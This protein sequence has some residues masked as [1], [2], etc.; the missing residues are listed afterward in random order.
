MTLIYQFIEQTDDRGIPQLC[1]ARNNN[2]TYVL[3]SA[4]GKDLYY[5]Y[6]RKYDNYPTSNWF[7][8]HFRMLKVMTKY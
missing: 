2:C 1:A 5:N 7:H 8:R 6:K 4:Y 3:R